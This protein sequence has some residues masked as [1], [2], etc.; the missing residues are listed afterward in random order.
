MIMIIVAKVDH[1]WI[2]INRTWKTQLQ[3]AMHEIHKK[4]SSMV[5]G[6]IN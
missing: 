6:M 5:N 3:A 1:K 2:R 4:Q